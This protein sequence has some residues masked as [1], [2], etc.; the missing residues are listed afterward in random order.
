MSAS[1]L[2]LKVGLL[3]V[4]EIVERG[5]SGSGWVYEQATD[6]ARIACRSMLSL[7][8][9]GIVPDSCRR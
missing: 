8:D 2:I 1:P 9:H 4:D 5:R 3:S 7:S 6:D